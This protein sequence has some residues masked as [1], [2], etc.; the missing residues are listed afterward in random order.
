MHHC[1]EKLLD[2]SLDAATASMA[3]LFIT[4]FKVMIEFVS[5]SGSLIDIALSNNDFDMFELLIS[6]VDA[7]KISSLIEPYSL[8]WMWN[9]VKLRFDLVED[10]TPFV[11]FEQ[12]YDKLVK[13]YNFD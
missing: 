2:G 4:E 12:A 7:E 10:K 3:K 1:T 8:L 13:L 6:S 5:E 9:D 11:K